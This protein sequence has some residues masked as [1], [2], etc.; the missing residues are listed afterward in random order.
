MDANLTGVP[1]I[2]NRRQE[3][4]GLR[5]DLHRYPELSFQEERTAELVAHRLRK[6]GLDVRSGIAKPA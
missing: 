1:K 6:A 4:I 2:E 3:L 5:R